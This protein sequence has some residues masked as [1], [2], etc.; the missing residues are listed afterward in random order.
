MK[1]VTQCYHEA[2]TAIEEG[3]YSKEKAEQWTE[4]LRTVYNRDFWGGYYLG[5]TAG[6]WADRYGSQATHY[7]Q[8]I[9]K[10]TNFFRKLSVAEVTVEEEELSVGDQILIIG[11]TTG[12]YEDTVEEI[13]VDYQPALTAGKGVVCSIP[14]KSQVRIGDQIYK[15]AERPEVLL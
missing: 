5:H 14:V 8:R 12:V 4:R 15:W 11:A 3:T 7:R 9:G 2:V 10:I 1:V 6:E 13:R